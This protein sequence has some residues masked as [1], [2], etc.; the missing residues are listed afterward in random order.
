M[1]TS[2]SSRN[3]SSNSNNVIIDSSAG[4]DSRN[5]S[6]NLSIYDNSLIIDSAKVD[7]LYFNYAICDTKQPIN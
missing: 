3:N 1:P 6:S 5:R 2:L 7:N 4:S